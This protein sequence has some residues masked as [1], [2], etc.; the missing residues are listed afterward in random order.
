MRWNHK[1]Q[2][3]GGTAARNSREVFR[4]MVKAKEKKKK[5]KEK[6]EL[7]TCTENTGE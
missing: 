2:P 4:Q 6:T 5:N 7:S 3:E 1:G